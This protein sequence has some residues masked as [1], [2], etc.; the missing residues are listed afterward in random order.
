MPTVVLQDEDI[1][2]SLHHGNAEVSG[3]VPAVLLPGKQTIRCSST[4]DIL[5]NLRR[6]FNAAHLVQP[7]KS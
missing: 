2:A 7:Q 4:L 6:S 1:M 3:K 5:F